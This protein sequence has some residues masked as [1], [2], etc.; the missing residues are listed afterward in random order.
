MAHMDWLVFSRFSEG[1]VVTEGIKIRST[2]FSARFRRCPCTS[3]AGKQT[4]SDVTAESPL[5]YI[6][7]VLLSESF[8][9]KPK[10]FQ[11]VFQKGIFS[12]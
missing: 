2:F 7:L 9:E 10:A 5:S 3:L 4:V 12:Q 1:T 8:T 6:F 11:N